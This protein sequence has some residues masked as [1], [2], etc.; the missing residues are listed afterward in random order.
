MDPLT[1]LPPLVEADWLQKNIARPEL[2]VVDG[3]WHMPADGRDPR[4]EYAA[5]HI[6]GA[7][8]FDI[9][10]I[11]DAERDLPHM[12]PSPPD[13]GRAVGA[14]G[15]ASP[16]PV[17][18][19]DTN[20]VF[21]AARVWW[22]FRAM[23][24]EKIAVLNGGLPAWRDAGG[25]VEAGVLGCEGCPDYTPRPRPD[26]VASAA[27]VRA[28]LDNGGTVLDARPAARF[29]GEA[30]EPRS[31]LRS[32]HMPGSK[33]LPFADLLTADG[34]MKPKAEL[35]ALFAERGADAAPV[36]ASCGSGVTAAVILLA[37]AVLG[38]D[39]DSLYDGS[40]AE[41]GAEAND[42][43]AFPVVKGD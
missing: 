5:A 8:F 1:D 25:L 9:D 4:A 23:G 32:G 7:V 42:T 35:E 38:H 33:N 15:I 43:D 11:A 41:W 6:P 17:V 31:G 13:F 29:R 14:M 2:R 37:R 16:N 40:W 24:H 10:Q 27:D 30:D 3:S 28:R 36:T 18:V 34:K 12:L 22:T 19:Y 21:S 39:G 20:G 26:L